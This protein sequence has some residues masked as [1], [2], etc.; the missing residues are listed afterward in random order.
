MKATIFH[1]PRDVRLE[2]VPDPKI[3][4]PNE[5]IVRRARLIRKGCLDPT[6]LVSHVLP[7][8]DAVRL[9]DLSLDLFAAKGF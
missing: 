4:A 1:G 3:S 5:A 8:R 2:S 6:Q 9:Q 7:L